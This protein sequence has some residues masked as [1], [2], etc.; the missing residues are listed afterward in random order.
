MLISPAIRLHVMGG[1]R[2]VI[3]MSDKSGAGTFPDIM[4]T[5][6]G[7]C[8]MNRVCHI[9]EVCGLRSGFRP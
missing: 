6:C 8:V 9:I 7:V 4:S 2:A 5:V 1:L 3:E